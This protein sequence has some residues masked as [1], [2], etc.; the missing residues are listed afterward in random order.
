MKVGDRVYCKKRG[1]AVII[2]LYDDEETAAVLFLKTGMYMP[3]VFHI[4]ELEVIN[5][6]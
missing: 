4:N 3:E 6:N 2:E 1:K 5:E